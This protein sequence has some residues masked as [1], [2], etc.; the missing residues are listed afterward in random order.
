MCLRG[1]SDDRGTREIARGSTLDLDGDREVCSQGTDQVQLPS[2]QL[3]SNG[4]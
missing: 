4:V 2:Q 3:L 1:T